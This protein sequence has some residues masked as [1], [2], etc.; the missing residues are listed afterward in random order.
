MKFCVQHQA[1]FFCLLYGFLW[2]GIHVLYLWIHT[3]LCSFCCFLLQAVQVLYFHLLILQDVSTVT[4]HCFMW[5]VLFAFSCCGSLPYDLY[6]WEG[7]CV[8]P[9]PCLPV[10]P[11]SYFLSL[12]LLAHVK[13][14][15]SKM[16]LEEQKISGGEVLLFWMF[17]HWLYQLD[18]WYLKNCR[19]G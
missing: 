9:F 1:M 15:K 17:F 12:Y 14:S 16:Y 10:L 11:S 2:L 13:D 4:L 5:W 8:F 19:S 7:W 6:I 3:S 18:L